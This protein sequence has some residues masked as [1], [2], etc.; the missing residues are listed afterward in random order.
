MSGKNRGTRFSARLRDSLLIYSS[1]MACA[2]MGFASLILVSRALGPGDFGVFSIAMAIMGIA[3]TLSDFG[4][5]GG[6]ARLASPVANKDRRKFENIVAA[7]LNTRLLASA[8]V[9]AAGA[10]LSWLISQLLIGGEGQYVI[11]ILAF[12]GGFTTSLFMHARVVL[13]SERRFKAL[14]TMRV[15]VT[16]GTLVILAALILLGLLNPGSSIL[17]Y[18]VTPLAAFALFIMIS[19]GH[20]GGKEEHLD[21]R[22]NLLE[23]S[24]WI[25]IVAILSA[26]F[27]RLDVLFLGA[28]WTDNDVGVYSVALTLIF[29]ITQLANSLATVL[30]PEVSSIV[31]ARDLE[32]FM[33][34]SLKY[35]LPISAALVLVAFSS[36]PSSLIPWVF[37]RE[38]SGSVEP[39][40]ILVLSAS[41]IL[42]CT[43]IYL[44]VYPMGKPKILAMGDFIKLLLHIGAYAILVPTLGIMGAAWGNFV[45][46]STG[47][48]ITVILVLR[49][50]RMGWPD[51]LDKRANQ[52]V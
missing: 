31:K 8:A 39:F 27:L 10:L 5:S 6:T 35:T 26:V 42:I 24:R 45:A 15:A 38:Y 23:F 48:V 50:L 17:G 4:L 3:F 18:A 40:Q 22:R 36:I 43:P 29:P 28:T 52:E 46:M 44:A 41:V 14:A 11:V 51:R 25:F 9:L 13:Q 34:D 30:I 2:L 1:D 12:V 21:E 49:E 33:Y 32:R 20:Q 47:S 7:A 16:A 19:H 37:G